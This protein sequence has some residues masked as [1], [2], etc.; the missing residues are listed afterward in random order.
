[1]RK[2]FAV[3]AVVVLAGLPLDA[4]LVLPAEFGEVV[5]DASL[6][7]RGRVTDVRSVSVPGAIDSIATVAVENVLKGHASG[8]IYVRVPGGLIGRTRFVMSGAPAFRT[9]QRAILFL[10]PSAT[11]TSYRPIGLTMGVYPVLS[12]SATRRLV[13]QPPLIAG[14]NAP[15]AGP[16]PRGDRQRKSMSVPEFES[17]VKVMVAD[18]RRGAAAPPG[19]APPNRGARRGGGR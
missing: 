8:F 15:A 2:V 9:G 18:P 10:R 5:A 4:H 7:V 1:M 11:D 19:A 6:I 16:T 17:L 12:D 13:V 14:R 3:V